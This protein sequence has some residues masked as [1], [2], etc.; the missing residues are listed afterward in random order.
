MAMRDTYFIKGNG[1]TWKAIEAEQGL[2]EKPETKKRSN[3][4]IL[5]SNR[6]LSGESHRLKEKSRI[7]HKKYW[8]ATMRS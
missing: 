1:L 7:E 4:W 3:Y 6:I 8:Q 2:R 5:D